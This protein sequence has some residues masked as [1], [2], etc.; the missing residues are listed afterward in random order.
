[1][2]LHFHNTNITLAGKLE[3]Q[4]DI[5]ITVIPTDRHMLWKEQ[6][7]SIIQLPSINAQCLII[8]H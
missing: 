1:M 8:S 2:P 7:E 5:L 3:I 4:T 6:G